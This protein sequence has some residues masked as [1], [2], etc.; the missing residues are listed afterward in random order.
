MLSRSKGDW[1]SLPD[2]IRDAGITA[3]AIDLRGHGASSGSAG[4][5]QAMVQ[6]VRAAAQWLASRQNVRPDAIGVVGASLGASLALLAAA[7][8]P[9]VRVLALVS[10]SLDYRG[11]RTDTALV[12][13]LGARSMWL[14][15]SSDD[16]LALRTVRDFAAESSGPREQHV[17]SVAAH[18][19]VLLERDDSAARALV[20]WLRRTLVS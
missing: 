16:P 3:L 13:R 19:T 6:D 9:Q 4:D 7:D 17:S 20:D 10:P 18:G 1:H 11:L 5:L 2:R 8:L 15:A 14:A 12:K